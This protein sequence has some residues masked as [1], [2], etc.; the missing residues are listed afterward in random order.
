MTKRRATFARG[1]RTPRARLLVEALQLTHSLR[2][3]PATVA[4]LSVTFR[5]SP[6]KVYRILDDLAEAGYAVRVDK[7]T[8]LGGRGRPGKRY[9]LAAASEVPTRRAG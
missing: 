5:L 3:K 1:D 7:T 9:W 6:R 8:K 2:R 4:E